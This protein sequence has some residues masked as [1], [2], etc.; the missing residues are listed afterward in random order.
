MF[1]DIKGVRRYIIKYYRTTPERKDEAQAQVEVE[2]PWKNGGA[3]GDV[4]LARE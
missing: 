4:E 3:V 1:D 2:V